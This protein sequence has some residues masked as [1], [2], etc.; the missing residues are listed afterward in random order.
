MRCI[1]N[2]RLLEFAESESSRLKKEKD[3][4]EFRI[5]ELEEQVK[6]L[7]DFEASSD[8]SDSDNYVSK[9]RYG[10][11]LRQS[12]AQKRRAD[13]FEGENKNLNKEIS[14]L[15]SEGPVPSIVS[16][17][18]HDDTSESSRQGFQSVHEVVK[19]AGQNLGGLRFLSS[20]LDTAKS[21]YTI[22]YDD[23]ADEFYK[24]FEVLETCANLRAKGS[25][26]VGVAEWLEGH[27]VKY[28][29]ESE[30]TKRR[31]DCIDARTFFDPKCG[32]SV[33][34]MHH[35]KMFRNAIRIHLEWEKD[36]E[37][38]LIGYIGEHLP[39]SSDLH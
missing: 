38:W 24:M 29:D 22:D 7:L 35:V 18:E 1:P 23:R 26:G 3:E 2:K 39:T 5:L 9:A 15:K 21:N 27:G 6:R 16:D 17:Q 19:H 36:E 20:S 25:L 28:S 10:R 13:R 37:K 33:E 32:K 12:R 14:R 34:M 4:D 30:D 31:P 11:L 8:D